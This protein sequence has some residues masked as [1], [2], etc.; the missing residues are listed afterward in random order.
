M[1]YRDSSP[2]IEPAVLRMSFDIDP[3]VLYLDL[4]QCASI[5]NRKFYRQG[6]N[7][8]VAGIT[9]VD[10]TGG[11]DGPVEVSTLPTTWVC[12]NA[13]VKSFSAWNKMNR[14][15]MQETESI[16][17]AYY[18]F[19]IHFDT[20]HVAGGFDDNIRPVGWDGIPTNIVGEWDA[21][22][23]VIPTVN[24]ATTPGATA[25]FFAKM[26]QGSDTA[27]KGLIEGYQDSRS[28]PNSPDPLIPGDMNE[29][30]L[31]QIF[32]QGTRQ[33][34]NVLEDLEE[35]NDQTPYDL[36]RYP[37]GDQLPDG[38]S[39]QIVDTVQF[40]GTT[41]SSR[42]RVGGFTAPCGLIRINQLSGRTLRMYVDLVP[43]THDGYMCQPMTE[44]N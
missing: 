1:A 40:T 22:I 9:F 5:Y 19:K 31:S 8:A 35:R 38:L 12:A 4:S 15:A 11:A 41:V 29:N 24:P 10:E 14:E 3:D 13:W 43:G 17:P 20:S 42:N 44:M 16:R 7:W 25:D 32:S 27:A 26:C 34:I 18:D 21:S 2:K 30:W 37:G 39:G 6:L 33:T 23:F 28:V 36:Y